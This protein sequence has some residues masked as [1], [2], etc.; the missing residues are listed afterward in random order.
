MAE[1]I[2]EYETFFDGEKTVRRKLKYPIK[3]SIASNIDEKTQAFDVLSAS[4]EKYF[5]GEKFVRRERKLITDLNPLYETPD[6]MKEKYGNDFVP[7]V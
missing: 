3:L 6:W 7:R 1:R 4:Y 5:D 2:I